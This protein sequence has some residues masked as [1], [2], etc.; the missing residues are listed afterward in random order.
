M[1]GQVPAGAQM[2][3]WDGRDTAGMI[4]T[5][6]TYFIRVR[7]AGAEEVRRVTIVR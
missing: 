2:T 5:P 1:G 3:E 7:A 6:G 4:A